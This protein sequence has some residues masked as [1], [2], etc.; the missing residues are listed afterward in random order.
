MPKP[1]LPPLML[2]EQDDMVEHLLDRVDD[3]IALGVH[4]SVAMEAATGKPNRMAD[5]WTQPDGAWMGW[6]TGE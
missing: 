2:G 4:V 1:E 6:G 3:L 5:A